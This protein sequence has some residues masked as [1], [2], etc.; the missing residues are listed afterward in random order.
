MGHLSTSSSEGQNDNL[1]GAAPEVKKTSS[2]GR[3]WRA[4]GLISG[5]TM[6]SRVLGLVREQVFAGLLG[7]GFYADAFQVAFRIP[8]LMRDL[9]A[10]G[11]LSAAFVPTYAKALHEGGRAAGHRLAS[12]VMSVLMILLGALVLLAMIGADPIVRTLAGGFAGEPGKTELTVTL[13][14]VM[15]PFLPLVSLA[16][17]A[18]GMLNAEE[19]FGPPALAPAMF[20]V[21]TIVCATVLWALGLDAYYV[22]VGWAIG[23]LLGGLA[24]FGVQLPALAEGGWRFR[25]EWAPSDPALRRIATLMAPA[26][27]GMAAVQ[28][29]IFVS[30]FF[31]SYERGAVAWLNYAFRLLYLPIG[32]F[33]VAMGTVAAS[34][35][36]RQA[37]A[38]EP[39]ALRETLW[40]SL[41][42]L[43]FLTVP[44]TV[45]LAV[46]ATP[47]VRLLYEHG[48][49]T[50]DD[51]VH[52]AAAL[53]IYSL[54][55]VAYASVKVLAP[56]FYALGRARV[57]LL[58]SVL[59]VAANVV[60]IVAL[61]PRFGY[62]GVAAGML[63]S[64]LMNALVLLIVFE[65]TA[66]GGQGSARDQ[67]LAAFAFRVGAAAAVMGV[68]VYLS[69]LWLE[70]AFGTA[71]VP[72]QLLG[73]LA[74][75]A[76][77][78]AVYGAAAL[79]LAV[80]EARALADVVKRRSRRSG[81]PRA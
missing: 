46:L 80:P 76:I 2:G 48:R 8:N 81:P 74:P 57:P 68:A 26:T 14:R 52:T 22:V 18:M 50:P 33:G 67:P 63:V 42:S 59:A 34:G 7:A 54:G 5:L 60:V 70:R 29:N 56:A 65:R 25:F 61:H 31:A 58:A 35:L 28:I 72:L 3:L 66:G 77:G 39:E 36:A 53:F 24:Q 9:F 51:T 71:G 43:A 13:T 45:G 27:M 32:V 37:A 10:E 41:K 47:I 20:N 38:G 12:R 4:A 23:T 49:F 17:V 40:R 15:L 30:T 75:I 16:A 78:I 44:S 6:V 21:V 64:S 11:A 69:N 19:R 55:L 73:T 1:Q 79:V 62:R